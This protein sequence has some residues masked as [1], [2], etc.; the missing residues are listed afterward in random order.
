MPCNVL[1]HAIQRFAFAR[2]Q[3]SWF[4]WSEFLVLCKVIPH[5]PNIILM[6]SLSGILLDQTSGWM[7]GQL[8]LSVWFESK[9]SSASIFCFD[10]LALLWRSYW[11]CKAIHEPLQWCRGSYFCLRC[12]LSCCCI[13]TLLLP[14]RCLAPAVSSC[15]CFISLFLPD[16]CLAAV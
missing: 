1:E 2:N 5:N 9:Y 4:R 3:S 8:A 6:R 16:C 15:C 10:S 14:D 7:H 11:F 12:T 13:I